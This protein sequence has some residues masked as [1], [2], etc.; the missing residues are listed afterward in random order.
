ME[1]MDRIGWSRSQ[2]MGIHSLATLSG[3]DKRVKIRPF[4]MKYLSERGGGGIA[5]PCT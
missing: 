4:L 2:G 5:L 3:R 1:E